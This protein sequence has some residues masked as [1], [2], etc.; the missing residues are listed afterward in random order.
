MAYDLN[1]FTLKKSMT[2]Q[3]KDEKF[4]V[5]EHIESLVKKFFKDNKITDD[6]KIEEN[7][8]IKSQ[9]ITLIEK[10]VKIEE[11]LSQKNSLILESIIEDDDVDTTSLSNIILID[12]NSKIKSYFKSSVQNDLKLLNLF[13]DKK[14]I[15]FLRQGIVTNIYTELF[16]MQTRKQ[17]LKKYANSSVL[18]PNFNKVAVSV[19]ILLAH[20]CF[21]NEYI[22]NIS[23]DEKQDIEK[24]KLKIEK[25]NKNNTKIPNGLIGLLCCYNNISEYKILLDYFRDKKNDSI[26]NSLIQRQLIEIQEEEE[27]EKD[28]K[29]LTLIDD[30]IS[31]K[32]MSQYE[33]N[34]YP[35]WLNLTKGSKYKNYFDYIKKT[36]PKQN[37]F[38][39]EFQI[40]NVLIAG[41]GTGKHPIEVAKIDP[42]LE[43]TAIDISKPSIAY[44]IRKSHEFGIKN[45][46]WAQADILK[47]NEIDKKFDLVESSGVIHHLEDPYKGFLMLDEKLKKGGF[48]KLGLYARNFRSSYLNDIK[49]YKNENQFK[50][51]IKSIRKLRLFLINNIEND[52]YQK[53]FKIPDIY[54]SSGFRDLIMHVQE[55]DFS[56]EELDKMVS[57]RYNFLGFFWNKSNSIKANECFEKINPEKS[58]LNIMNWDSVEKKI[59]EI[60]AGMYQFWLQK[61]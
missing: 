16:L 52:K 53:L 13:N 26:L 40:K 43:I 41:C 37:L 21:N 47:L 32:V 4:R 39:K 34:P 60:F 46:R 30:N 29:S 22:W 55:H 51:D 25:I 48:M 12:F 17:L 23:E 38:A 7:K 58:K 33:S 50:N 8:N 18:D 61:K 57:D 36:L 44:G 35:R 20:Q 15:F 9:L 14:I 42:T 45:I 56:I 27:I 49:K 5:N 24:I 19:I 6:F 28:I 2:K 59:P 31:L 11:Q 3:K 10:V 1:R 54:N